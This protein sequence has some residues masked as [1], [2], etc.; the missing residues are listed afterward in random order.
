[1]EL[2]TQMAHRIDAENLKLMKRTQ[3]LNIKFLCQENDRDFVI[4]QI[5]HHKKANQRLKAQYEV[6]KTKV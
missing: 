3:E 5:I 4:R 1:M 2:I 6:L